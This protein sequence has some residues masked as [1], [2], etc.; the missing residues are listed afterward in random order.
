MSDP[1]EEII[2]GE[3][4]LRLPLGTR[5]ELVCERLHSAL[6]AAV[7]N[8]KSTRLLEIRSEVKLD[9]HSSLRPD[10]ALVT[11]A[12]SKLWLAV[13]VVS[14]D[15]HKTD[16]VIKKEVYESARLPRLW[17]VDPRYDNVEVY[18]ATEHGMK[19]VH[20]L[21]GRDVLSEKL[22]PEFEISVAELF[23]MPDV[24]NS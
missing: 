9:T 5:H 10:I 18:H 19:L 16:T 17:M 2:Q 11:A 4:T 6:K 24:G 23:A 12:N 22:L 21:A 3:R 14:A 7:S 8:F 13:E 15:D 20:I 1:Y